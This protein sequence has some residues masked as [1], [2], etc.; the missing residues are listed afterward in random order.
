MLRNR[1]YFLNRKTNRI[2]KNDNSEPPEK[3][4]EPME[5]SIGFYGFYKISSVI[6][7]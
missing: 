4:M 1:W 6:K 5:N 3:P 2:F 7:G